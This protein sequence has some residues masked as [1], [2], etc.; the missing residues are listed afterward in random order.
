MFC[1][2]SKIFIQTGLM[3]FKCQIILHK[4]PFDNTSV[5]HFLGKQNFTQVQVSYLY[6]KSV[7]LHIR[8][9]VK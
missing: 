5:H 8:K 1:P 3:N 2:G 4:V 7:K 9:Y 6:E